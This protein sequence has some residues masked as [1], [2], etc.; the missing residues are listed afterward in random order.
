MASRWRKRYAYSASA[1][2]SPKIAPEAPT[3]GWPSGVATTISVDP[4]RPGDEVQENELDAT[5]KRFDEA[6]D[7]VQRPHVEQQ[8]DDAPVQE[9]DADH[10]PVLVVDDD[11]VGHQRSKSMEHHGVAAAHRLHGTRHQLDEE[12]QHVEADEHVGDR[13]AARPADA[14]LPARARLLAGDDAHAV[15]TATLLGH[16]LGTA[17]ADRGRR[18]AVVADGTAAVGA[19]HAGLAVVMPV[20]VLDALGQAQFEVVD[21]GRWAAHGRR[22]PVAQAR[23]ASTSSPIQPARRSGRSVSRSTTA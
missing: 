17:E 3:V 23:A 2:K 12:H 19:V 15:R 8:V 16:A 7:H 9:H 6:A 21:T 5:Q 20:A 4:P 11:V 14:R 18:H 22:P 13:E 10:A 1:P